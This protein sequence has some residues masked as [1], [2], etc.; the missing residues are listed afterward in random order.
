MYGKTLFSCMFI[1]EAKLLSQLITRLDDL[2]YFYFLIWTALPSSLKYSLRSLT[3][4]SLF[5]NNFGRLMFYSNHYSRVNNEFIGIEY[6]CFSMSII[7][8]LTHK[9]IKE[10][11]QMNL[12]LAPF[13]LNVMSIKQLE[14]GVFFGTNNVFY[15]YKYSFISC[16]KIWNSLHHDPGSCRDRMSHEAT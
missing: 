10:I 9:Y 15:F 11:F 1:C 4:L 12:L 2:S 7:T 16:I 14:N 5:N 3:R 13:S 8:L 6:S